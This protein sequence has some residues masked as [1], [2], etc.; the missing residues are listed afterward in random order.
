MT[1]HNRW[2]L[3]NLRESPYFQRDLQASDTA[4][5]P[6]DL[7]IGRTAEAERLLGVIG[8]APSSR[9][10]IEGSPGFGKT[11]L[12]QYVKAR[13]AEAGYVSYPDPVSAAGVDTAETLLVRLLSYVYDALVAQLGDALAE[14]PAMDA[15]RRLV[16]DTR[17][18]D[19]KVAA[20]VAGFGFDREVVRRTEPAT[21]HSGLLTIP[22]LLRALPALAE[23]HG[24]PG[25]VVHLNN[26][27]NLV[28]DEER[29]QAGNALRDLRDI[30]L[31]DGYHFLLV[32]TTDAVRALIAPHAQLRSV[33]GI[34]RPL[35]PLSADAFQ[36][37]LARRYTHLRLDPGREVRPPVAHD[38]AA[39]LY[40]IYRGDL[41]GTLRAMD[42]AAHELIGYTDPPGAPIQAEQLFSVLVPMLQAELDSTLS[43]TLQDYF[44]ALTPVGRT[45]FTQ[46]EL[47]EL[48][49]VTQGTVSANL[50]ELLR[51]GYVREARRQGRQVWYSLTGPARL[52]LGIELAG[53]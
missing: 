27:E 23:R 24:V 26:L 20:Q 46:K 35:E 9:Q 1:L 12:A 30:F 52:V 10:T 37:L 50:R 42:A 53:S 25:I 32:G 6:I 49:N 22:P 18:R 19:I 39:D 33:F 36:A 47:A 11:T 16:L 28:T 17:V 44:Y 41:R 45:E 51:L 4:R 40:G 7:F 34:T 43:E 2:Q 3:Y 29:T 38:A 15:A 13:A 5:Y 48:W 14:D 31:L 8:G 21:F